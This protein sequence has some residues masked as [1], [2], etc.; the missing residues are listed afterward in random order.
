MA[1]QRAWL[2]ALLALRQAGVEQYRWWR[3]LRG[4]GRNS[5]P[6]FRHLRRLRFIIGWDPPAADDVHVDAG[7]GRRNKTWR[8]RR[9]SVYRKLFEEDAAEENGSFTPVESLHFQIGGG[10]GPRRAHKLTEEVVDALRAAKA[11]HPALTARELV[12]FVRERFG[13]SV[14]RR[15]I[16]RALARGEKLS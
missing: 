5:C 8:R 13:I 4:S 12:E 7:P 6:Q 3:R 1:S 11:E 9:R 14:H 16:D 10:T 15:S 2:A